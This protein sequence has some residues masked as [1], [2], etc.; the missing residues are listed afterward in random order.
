M[1]TDGSRI[2]SSGRIEALQNGH[3]RTWSASLSLM[4][5]SMTMGA[6]VAQ[7]FT[8]MRSV[9]RFTSIDASRTMGCIV[10]GAFHSTDGRFSEYFRVQI[11]PGG[12]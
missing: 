2:Q 1:K 5:N 3:A 6:L 12:K 10:T 7:E 11:S 9:T 4:L 8:A